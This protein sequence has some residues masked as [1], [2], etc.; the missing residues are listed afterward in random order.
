[1]II[2]F[3]SGRADAKLF[4]TENHGLS[5]FHSF[6]WHKL[7]GVAMSSV[8]A[9]IPDSLLNFSSKPWEDTTLLLV[10]MTIKVNCLVLS[11]VIDKLHSRSNSCLIF[12]HS[13]FSKSPVCEAILRGDILKF[14]WLTNSSQMLYNLYLELCILASIQN[15]SS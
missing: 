4:L 13:I 6:P 5:S 12:C 8:Q 7:S 15:A 10:Q 11:G 9:V 14:I 1:M 3:S 2:H